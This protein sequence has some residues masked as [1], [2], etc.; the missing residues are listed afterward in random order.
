MLV[1]PPIGVANKLS[2]L[3][4]V[5]VTLGG[6]EYG[7]LH[8]EA[9]IET[10]TRMEA[11]IAPR[12]ILAMGISSISNKVSTIVAHDVL[13]VKFCNRILEAY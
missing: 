1:G 9:M 12:F 2:G 4:G 5:L 7:W 10:S 13:R 3:I 6:C 11:T 8:A